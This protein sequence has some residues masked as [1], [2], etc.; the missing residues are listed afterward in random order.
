MRWEELFDDLE[1][2]LGA[3][4]RRERDSEVADRTRR[5]RASITLVA[6]L[7]SSVGGHLGLR[8]LTGARVRGELLD[9]GQDWLLLRLES[10]G[11]AV[12]P[13]PALVGVS[14]LQSRASAAVSARRFGLGYALRGLSRDRAH[15]A[16]TDVSGQVLTGTIDV[17]GADVLDLA[18]HARGESRRPGNLTGRQS[19]PFS[20]L[21]LVESR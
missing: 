17:V 18:E 13:V 10:G 15:V 9:L 1:A 4:E 5:E 14:G 11:E 2:Q 3:E 8:L 16:V 19:V 21:V 7:A 6:R 20:A 12:V